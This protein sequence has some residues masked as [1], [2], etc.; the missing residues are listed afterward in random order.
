MLTPAFHFNILKSYVP[1]FGEH[2]QVLVSRWKKDA[3]EGQFVDI[4]ENIT[5]ATLGLISCA[6]LSPFSRD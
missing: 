3:E 5:L 6:R 4:T 2:T 1:I